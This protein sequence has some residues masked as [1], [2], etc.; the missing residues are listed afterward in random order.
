MSATRLAKAA[1]VVALAAGW[2]VAG[3][4]LWRTT[5]PASLRLPHV[6]PHR[7]W[8]DSILHRAA[9]FDGFLRWNWLLATLVQIAALVL[10][11]RLGPRLA[12]AWERGRVGEGVLVGPGAPLV[13]W[14]VALP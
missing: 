8:S 11:V 5:V 6:D 14:A 12:G 4:F 3:V 1:T 13:A 10:L 9:S 2:V 7:Y